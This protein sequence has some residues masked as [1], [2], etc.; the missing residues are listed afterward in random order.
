MDLVEAERYVK[1][2]NAAYT[3]WALVASIVVLFIM[4]SI[5]I[6]II[7]SDDGHTIYEGFAIIAILIFAIILPLLLSFML[8]PSIISSFK[9]RKGKYGRLTKAAVIS[10]LVIVPLMLLDLSLITFASFM[11]G[12]LLMAVPGVLTIGVLVLLAVRSIQ[13]LISL[14]G[15]RPGSV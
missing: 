9:W 1:G 7:R 3:L 5:Q 15:Y 4:T 6:Y 10:I 13:F 11:D 12:F 8:V 2:R 14:K